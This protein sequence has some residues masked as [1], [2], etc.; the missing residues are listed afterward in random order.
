MRKLGFELIYYDPIINTRRINAES[1]PLSY[2]DKVEFYANID[3]LQ[4][5][6]T[7]NYR[8]YTYDDIHYNYGNT[9]TFKIEEQPADEKQVMLTQNVGG[10]TYEI[11]KINTDKNDYHINPDGWK[12]YKKTSTYTLDDNIYLDSSE[13]HHGGQ[14][15]CLYLSSSSDQLFIFINSKDSRN[16]Y[17][18]DGY[19]YRSSLSNVSFTRETVF[20][21]RNWGWF[22][23]FTYSDGVLSIQHFSYAGYYAMTS[24]RNSDGTWTTKQGKFI[25]PDAFNEQSEQAGNV[26]IDDNP[27]LALSQTQLSIIP[28]GQRCPPK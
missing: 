17:T 15:P 23:Y 25:K 1:Y 8:A 3:N 16:S 20:T 27:G 21:G 18:M 13:S 14:R 10:T 22:P 12:C 24:Y 28:N 9:Y 7:Y 2:G 5:G 19:A 6:R 4:P 11:Y 26:L